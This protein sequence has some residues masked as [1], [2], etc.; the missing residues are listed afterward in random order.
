MLQKVLQSFS[1]HDLS[2]TAAGCIDYKLRPRPSTM[3]LLP[4][5]IKGSKACSLSGWAAAHPSIQQRHA[6][7]IGT[8]GCR[9]GCVHLKHQGLLLLGRNGH[10]LR[11]DRKQAA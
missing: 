9:I 1:L 8:L 10:L 3:S 6:A 2:D 5:Y 4:V 11:L 7:S